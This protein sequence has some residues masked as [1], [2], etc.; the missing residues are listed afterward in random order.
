MTKKLFICLFT[1]LTL[2]V[3][4]TPGSGTDTSS[5]ISEETSES[6]SSGESSQSGEESETTS[7]E[8][9]GQSSEEVSDESS[10][11][12]NETSQPA[13]ESPIEIMYCSY[14]QRPYAVIVGKCKENAVIKAVTTDGQE[15]ESESFYGWF[16]VRFRH[17]SGTKVT[18]TQYVDGE[19]AGGQAIYNSTPKNPGTAEG[20]VA[21]KDYQFFYSKCLSDFMRYNLPDR[22]RLDTLTGRVKSR[23]KAINDAGLDTKLI[24]I[25][26]PSAITVYP[27]A[28]PAEY[29]QSTGK[30][31]RQLIMDALQEAGATVIDLETVFGLHKNDTQTIYYKTDS[32]WTE[33]AAFLA[34][35]ELFNI[36]KKDYPAA[37]PYDYD[38]FNWYSGYFKT[39]DMLNYLNMTTPVYLTPGFYDEDCLEYS[40]FRDLSTDVTG[41]VRKRFAESAVYSEEV[42]YSHL[43]ETNRQN[44]PSCI[45]IRDSFGTQITDLIAGNMNLTYF[46]KMWDYTYNLGNIKRY[47]ADYVIYIV[48]EWN[49]EVVLNH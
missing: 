23:I 35:T 26:V 3:S 19:Q 36:I 32:H 48:S 31:R 9:T 5:V 17:S 13:E 6:F 42:T 29:K 39:G 14:D 15:V 18:L 1:L 4:C 33:Y 45:V 22:D 40:W 34:Y 41:V 2:L 25:I 21:G 16:S 44:L 11:E 27:E 12:S 37:A 47:N 46:Q 24:Y 8:E 49:A 38:Y 28:V 30:T 10:E 20:V 43:I 7:G